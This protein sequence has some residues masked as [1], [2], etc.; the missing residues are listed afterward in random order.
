M[1][2]IS[3]LPEIETPGKRQCIGTK[4]LLQDVERSYLVLGFVILVKSAAANG[5]IECDRKV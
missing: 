4:R 5:M 1:Y 2:S 3:I